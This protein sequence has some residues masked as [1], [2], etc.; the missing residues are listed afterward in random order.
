MTWKTVS[1]IYNPVHKKTKRKPTAKPFVEYA[2]G[3]L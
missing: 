3:F 1:F 2:L